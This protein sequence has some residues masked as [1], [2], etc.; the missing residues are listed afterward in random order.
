LTITEITDAELIELVL[1]NRVSAFGVAVGYVG[2]GKKDTARIAVTQ[3]AFGPDSLEIVPA[4]IT[5]ELT[6]Y[7]HFSST[8]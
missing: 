4:G 7:R 3:R 8:A 6:N 1:K 2:R 5:A